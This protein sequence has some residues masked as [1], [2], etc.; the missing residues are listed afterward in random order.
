MEAR[1]L[2]SLTY[3]LRVNLDQVVGNDMRQQF[4]IVQTGL[5]QEDTPM[6]AVCLKSILQVT[7]EFPQSA[8]RQG[9]AQ[10]V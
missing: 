3:F 2:N 7:P 9:L 8:I 10:I 6:Q 4:E 1:E 5:L